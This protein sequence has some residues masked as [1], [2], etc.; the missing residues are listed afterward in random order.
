MALDSP[1]RRLILSVGI[2]LICLW[3]ISNALKMTSASLDF[4]LVKNI[5]A[6]WQDKGEQQSVQQYQTAKTAIEEALSSHS[7]HPLYVDLMAQI[8]EWGAIAQYENK[9]E[10]LASAKQYY[11]QATTIRPSWPV[12]WAS[13][14]MIKWRQQEF[15]QEMLFYL[16]MANEMGPKKPEVHILYTQLGL[17]LYQGNNLLFLEIKNDVY[18]RI[19]LGLRNSQSRERVIS[20]IERFEAEKVTCRWLRYEKAW[21]QKLIPNCEPS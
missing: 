12:T 2:I 8:K 15:D 17:A 18:K 1:K 5:L 16:Q 4:Y 10:S 19:A 13:L 3:G 14:V 21:I 7:D 20:I 6:L 11:L 9:A